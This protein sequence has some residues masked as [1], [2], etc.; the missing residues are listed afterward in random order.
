MYQYLI[1]PMKVDAYRTKWI[2][3][4]QKRSTTNKSVQDVLI[5]NNNE[6]NGFIP[7]KM[8][9]YRT[10]LDNNEQ[11]QTKWIITEQ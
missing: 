11:N 4:E 3:T 2:I 7:N 9:N 6:Q 1:K 8:D 5:P 10:K